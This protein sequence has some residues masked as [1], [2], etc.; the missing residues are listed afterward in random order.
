MDPQN[1]STCVRDEDRQP[2]PALTGLRFFAAAY[3]MLFHTKFAH[4]AGSHSSGLL[5]G[6]LSSGFLAVTLFFLLSGFILAYVYEGRTATVHDK[7]QFWQARFARIWPLYAASLLFFSLLM[8]CTPPAPIAAATLLMV[9][10]WN[11]FN[12]TMAQAWSGVC[13]TLSVEAFFYLLF[14]FVQSWLD[15]RSR[16]THSIFLAVNVTLCLVFNISWRT[17]GYPIYG[18]YRFVPLAV[19]HTPEFLIGMVVG[20]L[21][22]RRTRTDQTSPPLFGW[23]TYL[24]VASSLA[25]LCLRNIPATSLAVLAFPALLFG[26]ATEATPLRRFLSLTAVLFGGEISYAMYLLH[27]PCRT[28]ADNMADRW[29]ITAPILRFAAYFLATILASIIAHKIIEVP[30]RTMIRRLWLKRGRNSKTSRSRSS[31]AA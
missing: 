9:Q 22:L 17:P 1:T 16:R 29:H 13:W 28:I 19:L 20:N 15:R 3:I 25:L 4:D 24:A 10:A 27:I 12:T 7:R 31:A 11:P 8:H 2:L 26:V 18:L 5:D 23:C 21:Y 30:A 6:F 14:P